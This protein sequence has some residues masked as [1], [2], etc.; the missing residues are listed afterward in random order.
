[1]ILELYIGLMILSL[2]MLFIGYYFEITPLILI[3]YGFLF[4][5]NSTITGGG[6]QY[7][8]GFNATLS[9]NTT[10]NT[11]TYATYQTHWIGFFLATIGF[12]GATLSIWDIYKRKKEDD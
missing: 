3:S 12:L 6:I 9:G 11:P 2:I 8:S 1:M 10:I 5:V 4:I 7:E